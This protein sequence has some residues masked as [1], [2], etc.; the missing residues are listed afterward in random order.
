[1]RFAEKRKASGEALVS[2]SA[3]YVAS[4]RG[5]LSIGL[6]LMTEGHKIARELGYEYSIVLGDP[7]YYPKAGYRSANLFGIMAPFEEPSDAFMAIKLKPTA[8]PIQGIVEYDPAFG[9]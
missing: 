2:R 9:M 3:T 4:S 8:E 7:C 6:P 5:H 1:M